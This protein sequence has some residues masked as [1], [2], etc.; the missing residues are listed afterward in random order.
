MRQFN[1]L[2]SIPYLPVRLEPIFLHL[3]SELSKQTSPFLAQLVAVLV[4][5]SVNELR[6]KH[7]VEESLPTCVLG[8]EGE[9]SMS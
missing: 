6:G 7:L 3:V 8:M 4:V 1:V 9:A 5:A 2:T